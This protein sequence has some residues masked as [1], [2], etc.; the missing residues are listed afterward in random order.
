[1]SLSTEVGHVCCKQIYKAGRG[2]AEEPDEEEEEEEEGRLG[3]KQREDLQWSYKT[4][5]TAEWA[6]DPTR[7]CV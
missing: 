7:K 6:K 2:N 5:A 3:K 4:I 1:M